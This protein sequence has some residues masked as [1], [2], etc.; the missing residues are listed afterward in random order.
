MRAEIGGIGK[1]NGEVA[2][3]YFKNSLEGILTFAGIKFDRLQTMKFSNKGIEGG[4]KISGQYDIVLV[5]SDTIAIIE[6]KY[7]ARLTDVENLINK[8]LPDF[9]TV[10]KEYK[11]YTIYLGIAGMTIDDEAIDYA[12]NN[13]VGVLT[14]GNDHLHIID[15]HALAF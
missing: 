15:D 13:G 14:N 2:D 8:Q 6:V 10:F 12:K 3:A 1:S 4:K 5:N 11:N 9:K 7:K